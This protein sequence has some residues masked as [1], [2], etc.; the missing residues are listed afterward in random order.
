MAKRKTASAPP[1]P[2]EA[3]QD[4]LSQMEDGYQMET[5]SPSGNRFCGG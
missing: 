2:T 4:L 3:E 1:R 5:D